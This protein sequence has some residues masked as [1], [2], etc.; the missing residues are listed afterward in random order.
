M[1]ASS[2][3]S[4]AALFGSCLLVPPIAVSLGLAVAA[5]LP[6]DLEGTLVIIGL[7]GIQLALSGGAWVNGIL[8][9]NGPIQL[10]YLAGG[11]RQNGEGCGTIGLAFRGARAGGGGSPRR[12]NPAKN[13]GPK[14]GLPPAPSRRDASCTVPDRNDGVV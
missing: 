14:R 6:H 2:P 7:V 8:P 10:A 11:F 13:E 1:L 12:G 5:V 9:M 3:V 4:V